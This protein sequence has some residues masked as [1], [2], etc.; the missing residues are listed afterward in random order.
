MIK[1][2]CEHQVS[3]THRFAL[4][5]TSQ[6]TLP[7]FSLYISGSIFVLLHT[8]IKGKAIAASNRGPVLTLVFPAP[9][10]PASSTISFS[11]LSFAW[12]ECQIFSETDTV[13]VLSEQDPLFYFCHIAILTPLEAAPLDLLCFALSTLA[14]H[15]MELPLSYPCLT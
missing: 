9:L 7:C 11:L 13:G 6:S 4:R 12:P 5:S 15:C 14:S 8:T 10:S 3:C 1:A 2:R